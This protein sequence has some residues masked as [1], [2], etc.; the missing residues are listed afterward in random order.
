MKTTEEREGL[1]LTARNVISAAIRQDKK[2]RK[3]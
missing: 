1:T 2:T 3:V